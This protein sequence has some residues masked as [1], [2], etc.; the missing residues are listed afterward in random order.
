MDAK[1]SYKFQHETE[2]FVNGVRVPAWIVGKSPFDPLILHRI[3]GQVVHL[4]APMFK[5]RWFVGEKAPIGID[6][7]SGIIYHNGDLDMTLCELVFL[8]EPPE[9]AFDEPPEGAFDEWPL[10]ACMAVGHAI[11]FVA[12]ETT[13]G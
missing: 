4:G 7:L 6:A 8:D 2:V 12:E 10:E 13:E 11:G 1:F 9:G 3:V 5:A